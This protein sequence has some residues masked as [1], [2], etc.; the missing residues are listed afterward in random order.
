MAPVA[1]P[2]QIQRNPIDTC[3]AEARSVRDSMLKALGAAALSVTLL[4][5][6]AGPPA[7]PSKH[8][9]ISS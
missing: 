4:V 9:P 8:C 7:S 3:A 5:A 6:L 2:F 1:A